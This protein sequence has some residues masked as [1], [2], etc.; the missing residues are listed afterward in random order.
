LRKINTKTLALLG[1]LTAMEIVLSRFLS[2]AAWNTK[3]GFSFVPVAVSA[4]LFGPLPAGLMAA[5]ADLV[6]ALLFPIGP[7]FPGFTL[8]AFLTGLCFGLLLYPAPSAGRAAAAVLIS[9]LFLSLLLNTLWISV[10]YGAPFLP[11]L[12]TRLFQTAL[13]SLVQFISILLLIR[14]L[15]RLQ[16]QLKG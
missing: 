5:A 2:I 1:V 7:Y 13:M 8:T 6:G 4:L 10:L 15:P 12:G 16:T 11:L 3:I 9:Q 14:L